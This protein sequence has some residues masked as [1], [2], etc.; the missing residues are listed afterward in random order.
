MRGGAMRLMRTAALATT[1]AAALS[2]SALGYHKFGVYPNRGN[3]WMS[4]EAGY[5]GEIWVSSSTCSSDVLS[6]FTKIEASTNSTTEMANWPDGI[7]MIRQDCNG[8]FTNDI[9]ITIRLVSDSYQS[10]PG[11]NRKLVNPPEFCAYWGLSHPCGDRGRV[12][13]RSS[14]WNSKTS[15]N[16]QRIIMHETGHSLGLDEHCTSNA[17]MNDGTNTCNGGKWTTI[18]SYQSTD[19]GGIDAI[20]P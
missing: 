17:I 11:M 9:D 2:G 16:R 15:T 4:S 1:I 8:V 10:S 13:I 20:Y 3:L 12:T 14:W 6:A 18:M 7:R 19:R 5:L